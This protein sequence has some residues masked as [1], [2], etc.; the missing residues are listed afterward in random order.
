ME[1][2]ILL[3]SIHVYSDECSICY[4]NK[5]F[6]FHCEICSW[7]H[8]KDCHKLWLKE[9]KSCPQCR[10]QLDIDSDEEAEESEEE[11]SEEM[12]FCTKAM[13]LLM[14]HG[15]FALMILYIFF[16]LVMAGDA[17]IDCE[18]DIWCF[19]INLLMFIFVVACSVQSFVKLVVYYQS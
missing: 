10:V 17:T 14:L 16:I 12:S 5:P 3:K 18:D 1:T 9:S 15:I 2:D 11:E 8:C 6:G 19:F 13:Y 4:E 7:E